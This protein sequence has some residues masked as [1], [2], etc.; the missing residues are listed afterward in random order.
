MT[1]RIDLQPGH[2][3]RFAQALVECAVEAKQQCRRQSQGQHTQVIQH[4]TAQGGRHFGPVEQ[5]RRL[6]QDGHAKHHQGP[7]QVKRLAEGKAKL[8]RFLGA[9]QFGPDWQ[10]G[11]Q[12]AHQ[13]HIDAHVNGRADRERGQRGL[14]VAPGDDGV[15]DAEGHGGELA[16][17]HGAGMAGNGFEFR[18]RS[19]EPVRA[20]RL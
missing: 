12:H 19:Q 3:Q 2:Q 11:L 1:R 18:H 15:G 9:V 10:Q 5:D 7:A 13:C 8:P 20:T 17:Q 6:Q 4:F 14:G 16:D